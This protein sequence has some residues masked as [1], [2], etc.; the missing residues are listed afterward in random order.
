MPLLAVLAAPAHARVDEHAAAVDE[1]RIA[2]QIERLDGDVEAAVDVQ[3][4]RIRAVLREVLAMRDE[5]RDAGAVARLDVNALR[6]DR[7]EVER[8]IVLPDALP[9]ERLAV[10][11]P[12]LVR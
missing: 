6:D 7:G 3:Q 10:E 5:H 12:D 2:A 8:R 4:R 1:R 11:R 9:S